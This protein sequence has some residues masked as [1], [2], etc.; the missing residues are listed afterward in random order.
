VD[1]GFSGVFLRKKN[2][3]IKLKKKKGE[4][5]KERKRPRKINCS[6]WTPCPV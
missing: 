1:V 4:K 5:Q 2:K 6:N 3:K